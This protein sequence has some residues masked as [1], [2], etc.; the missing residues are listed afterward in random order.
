MARPWA[1]SCAPRAVACSGRRPLTNKGSPI[2]ASSIASERQIR[3][4]AER[5]NPARQNIFTSARFAHDQ[6][7][8]IEPGDRFGLRENLFHR[9]ALVNGFDD[10]IFILTADGGAK[11]FVFQNEPPLF[12]RFADKGFNFF[13]VGRFGDVIDRAAPH[14]FDAGLQRFIRRQ[15]DHFGRVFRLPDDG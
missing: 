10:E 2:R 7:G 12:D 15:H 4:R 5:M 13:R 1:A 6:N 9:R 8:R 14:R 11:A 3:P